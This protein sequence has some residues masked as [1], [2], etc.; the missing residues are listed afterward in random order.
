MSPDAVKQRFMQAEEGNQ[1]GILG[2]RHARHL[3]THG[4]WTN[5]EEEWFISS[6]RLLFATKSI[7]TTDQWVEKLNALVTE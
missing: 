2:E 4:A 1:T 5:R 3:N 7:E 6:K